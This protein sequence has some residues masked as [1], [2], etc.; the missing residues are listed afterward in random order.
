MIWFC[1]FTFLIPFTDS[2]IKYNIRKN[3]FEGMSVETAV[4][5]FKITYVK[6][7]GAAFG[8]FSGKLYFLEMFSL[9]IILGVVYLI[10]SKKITNKLLIIALSFIVGGGI[11]NF[12]DRIFLG[13]VIDY[14]QVDFFKPIC[15]LSDYFI[16]L[17][18][19][20]VVIYILKSENKFI[21]R[22]K[23]L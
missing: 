12:L 6:N 7:R 13:F 9:L 15:N 16:T 17:G 2:L 21:L 3:F 11:G 19:T 22:T 5:F 14:L 20:I 4:K 18:V 8:I 1:V 23:N 10:F